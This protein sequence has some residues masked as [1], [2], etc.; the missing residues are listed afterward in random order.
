MDSFGPTPV[1]VSDWSK[2]IPLCQVIWQY[3]GDS[4]K[5]VDMPRDYSAK[6]EEHF[7]EDTL[8]FEYEV[9]YAK[10]TKTYHYK[11]NFPD[12]T[13]SNAKTGKVRNLRRLI[14]CNA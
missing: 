11:V 7:R 14:A 6:Y 13:Q 4:N 10:G 8:H 3:M 9:P 2:K 5:F 1:F 12:M